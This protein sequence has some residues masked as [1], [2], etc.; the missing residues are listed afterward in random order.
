MLEDYELTSLSIFPRPR[1]EPYFQTWLKGIASF[2]D[3][4]K[5][6]SEQ[7]EQYLLKIGLS[8]E[9][10]DRIREILLERK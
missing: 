1:T 8:K 4:G 9:E 6:F 5:P 2:S 7:V 3:A 10:L